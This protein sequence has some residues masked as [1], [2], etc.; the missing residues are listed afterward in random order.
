MVF[1]DFGAD[2]KNILRSSLNEWATSYR[3]DYSIRDILNSIPQSQHSRLEFSINKKMP[4]EIFVYCI[5]C[6]CNNI[7]LIGE[8][9]YR[10]AQI[11]WMHEGN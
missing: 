4:E 5:E 3:L 8:F 9:Y 11:I 7:S 2:V 10:F 1:E 6:V